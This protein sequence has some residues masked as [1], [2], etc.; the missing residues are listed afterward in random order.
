MK[1]ILRCGTLYDGVSSEPSRDVAIVLRD[2][3]IEEVIP[4]KELLLTGTENVEDYSN[5]IVAPG[6]IDAHVHLLF[7]CLEDHDETRERLESSS[8]EELTAVALRNCADSLLGGIT[9]VRDL[10]DIDFVTVTVRNLVNSGI[11]PGPSIFA[12]G[13]PVTTTAGHL[14]WCGNT[15]DSIEEIRKAVRRSCAKEVDVIKVMASG[16]NMTRGSNPMMPQYEVDE[17]K[18]LVTEAHRLKRRVAAHS[19]E[20]QSI[21][22]SIAAGVDTLEHCTWRG[23][24]PEDNDP[25][26]LVDLLKGSETMVTLTLA[27]IHRALLGVHENLS[28]LVISSSCAASVSGDLSQDFNWARALIENGIDVALASDA[29][30]RFTSFRDFNETIEAAMMALDINL[31]F[32]ISMATATAAKALGISETVGTIKQGLQADISVMTLPKS[33]RGMGEILNVYK[34]GKKVVEDSKL[35][36]PATESFGTLNS[37]PKSDAQ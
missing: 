7:T 18:A 16:G 19:L 22:R 1:K 20:A 17:L 21:R 13:P 24:N 14:H 12:A 32:A 28:S 25:Q 29:G 8:H 5:Y 15:A 23:S 37:A 10:G 2:S 11:M 3:Q 26:Q 33:G 4:W 34:S 27:G 6:F 31:G 9:T 30:V 36:F 35:L